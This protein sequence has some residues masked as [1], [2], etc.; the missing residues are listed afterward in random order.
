MDKPKTLHQ[1]L[2]AI[3]GMNLTFKKTENNPYFKSKYLPLDEL[4][5]TLAPALQEQG[6]LVLHRTD[7]NAVCT[8]VFNVDD[9]QE[10]L[11]SRFP[12]LPYLEPQKVGSAI[13]YA[14]RYNLGQLFNIITDEDDDGNK[15][16]EKN[17][18]NAPVRA[19]NALQSTQTPTLDQL[20]AQEA[21]A[22]PNASRGLSLGTN[23][24]G[25]IRQYKKIQTN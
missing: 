19:Q 14:K 10:Q 15:A 25:V 16:S 7:D 4:Q 18:S 23:K 5:K 12:L 21:K 9:P 20:A 6:L 2:F 17:I 3:Q 13:S 1:K 11:F 24:G 8:F 22:H